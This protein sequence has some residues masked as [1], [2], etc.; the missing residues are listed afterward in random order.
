MITIFPL[1]IG[2]KQIIII[3]SYSR[4]VEKSKRATFHA[5]Y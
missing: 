3:K 2:I 1:V 4:D 5:S